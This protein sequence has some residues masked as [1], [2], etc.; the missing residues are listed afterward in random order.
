VSVHAPERLEFYDAW[1]FSFAF[2]QIFSCGEIFGDASMLTVRESHRKSAAV[3]EETKRLLAEAKE[4]IGNHKP[5]AGNL[6]TCE[7]D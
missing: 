4:L 3:R 6:R 7:V 5:Y 1:H 2:S